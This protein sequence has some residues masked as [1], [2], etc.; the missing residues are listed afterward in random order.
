MIEDDLYRSSTQYRKWSFTPSQLA[1][2]RNETNAY[3]AA[4]VRAAFERAGSAKNGDGEAN[5]TTTTEGDGL[6]FVDT[7]T[8]E[9]ELKIVEWGCGKI[10]EMGGALRCPKGLI[11]STFFVLGLMARWLDR[12][13]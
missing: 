2:Q 9:E 11:V 6:S 13:V 3:A 5:G 8:A 10:Q 4:K 12:T 7:L 1:A